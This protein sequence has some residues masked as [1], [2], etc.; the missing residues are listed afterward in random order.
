MHLGYSS[1]CINLLN[2]D[3]NIRSLLLHN[4]RKDLLLICCDLSALRDEFVDSAKSSI[5]ELLSIDVREIL[6][7][8]KNAAPPWD[9]LCPDDIKLLFDKIILSAVLA[10]NNKNEVSEFGNI[11]PSYA[12]EGVKNECDDFDF[13][14]SQSASINDLEYA[15][16]LLSNRPDLIE[17][18]IDRVKKKINRDVSP[19]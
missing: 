13:I 9:G 17:K 2:H 4:E 14:L 15:M 1:E 7:L 18:Y 5:S 11:I 3:I 8:L 19:G 16:E 6:F 10:F 12:V